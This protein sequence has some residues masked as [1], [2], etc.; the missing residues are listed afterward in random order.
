MRNDF[1]QSG[2]KYSLQE[3]YDIEHDGIVI[4]FEIETTL[5]EEYIIEILTTK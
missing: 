4:V 5:T 2:K 3:K 1:Y